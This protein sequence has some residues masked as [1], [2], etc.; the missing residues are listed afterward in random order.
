MSDA[1][2]SEID[3]YLGIKDEFNVEKLYIHKYVRPKLVTLKPRI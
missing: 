1:I 2:G 3:G